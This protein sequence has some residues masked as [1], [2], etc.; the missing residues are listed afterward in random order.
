MKCPYCKNTEIWKMY[1]PNW[2]KF[3]PGPMSNR[4]CNRC[5]QE[6]IRWF[7]FLPI[8]H[9]L[10]RVLIGLWHFILALL[11]IGFSIYFIRFLPTLFQNLKYN[12]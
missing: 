8:K 5:G 10:A 9:R 3:T 7:G 4:R 6:F 11:L 1:K 12:V 2:V